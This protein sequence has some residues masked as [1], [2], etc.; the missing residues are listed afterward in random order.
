MRSATPDVVTELQALRAGLDGLMP[1]VRRLQTEL[2]GEPLVDRLLMDLRRVE[3][4]VDQIRRESRAGNSAVGPTMATIVSQHDLEPPPL[5]P[6]PVPESDDDSLIAS[7]LEESD[8]E[9]VGVAWHPRENA[10]RSQG[11]AGSVKGHLHLPGRK[12]K[13]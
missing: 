2:G 13:A 5:A 9:G 4:D 7:P 1:H 11:G 3:E 12:G 8:A 6:V 10:P